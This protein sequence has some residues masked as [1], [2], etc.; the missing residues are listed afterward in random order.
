MAPLPRV[1]PIPCTFGKGST[2]YVY[3]LDT[4]EPAIVDT[5]V[6]ASPRGAV[7]PALRAAGID[8]RDVRWILAT[9]GHWDHIG[10]AHTLRELAGR[11]SQLALHG[12]DAELLRD[13]AAHMRGYYG[14]RYRY[15]DLPEVLSETE[16]ILMQ[17]ISGELGADREIEDGD[18]IQLGGGVTVTA[19]H[20]PG[21]SLGSV[22][23]VLDGPDWAFAGDAVQAFGSSASAFP[24]YVHP[25][26][27]RRSIRRLLDDVRPSRLHLGHRFYAAD[28]RLL[29]PVVEGPAAAQ[30]LEASLEMERRL[31]E[32]AASVPKRDGSLRGEDYRP[33]AAALGY[34][35]ED[36]AAWPYPFFTTLRG[37]VES[38]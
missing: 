23:Y 15:V 20:T 13:R 3:Y 33:A 26:G 31:R 22:T 37:Y 14:M 17:S 9:H 2:V 36:P 30:A 27:Y 32:A 38:P 35:D 10:G 6:A 19:V 12:A 1:I 28:G 11:G 16:A 25:E 7:E 24:L 4:P 34:P 18:R 29:E 5:G 21:H 8:I